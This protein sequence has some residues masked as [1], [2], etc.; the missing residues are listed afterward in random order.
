MEQYISKSAL[1]AEIGRRL[2]VHMES[3]HGFSARYDELKD[4]R[5]FLD[6]LEVKEVKEEPV[7]VWHNMD[8][9]PIKGEVIVVQTKDTFYGLSVQKGGSTYKNKN[10]D[11]YIRWAYA[12]DLLNL[13]NVQR[14]V[15]NWKEPVSD[16]LEEAADNY[17]GHAPDID[18]SLSIFCERKAF[19]AGAKWGMR[20]AEVKIQ[21]QSMAIA[22]GC[23]NDFAGSNLEEKANQL[24]QKYFPDEEN[25]WARSNIEAH[26]CKSACIEM[27]E[28]LKAQKVKEVQ[29]ITA[30]DR[31]MAEEIIINLKRI[32]N[33]YNID[34]TKCME[35]L[36]NKV[37]KGE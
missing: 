28:W 26:K 34:L 18:E 24:S 3:N 12:S 31:G 21:A 35:W 13:S 16:D 6:T 29:E 1:V 20:Q 32:E 9:V 8:E 7:S 4:I 10:K 27:V 19:K 2:K 11:R 5:S 14:T 33:D 30:S 22:H 37:K 25:I 36:R 23:P 17:V 15:K